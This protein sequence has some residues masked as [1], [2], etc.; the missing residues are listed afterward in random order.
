MAVAGSA[1]IV[2]SPIIGL[3]ALAIKMDDG[4][5][6]L[7]NQ[8]RVGRGGRN[9][10]CYKFRTMILGAEAIGNGLTVTADDSRITRVGHWLRL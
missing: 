9:F 2:L 8:D 5:P 7:F 1:L 4:G 3:I 6:V 10:R